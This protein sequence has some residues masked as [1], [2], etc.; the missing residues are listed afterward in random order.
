MYILCFFSGYV[1][2]LLTSHFPKKKVF[3]LIFCWISTYGQKNKR[4]T[5]GLF[6]SLTFNKLIKFVNN[7]FKIEIRC[8][9]KSLDNCGRVVRIE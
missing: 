7:V 3:L 9:F 5:F 1:R 4:N 2:K 6:L 8:I